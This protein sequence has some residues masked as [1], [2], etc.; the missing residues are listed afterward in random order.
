MR[1][2]IAD[3]VGPGALIGA[4]LI[5]AG[6]DVTFLD[7]ARRVTARMFSPL[8]LRSD[9]GNFRQ[10]AHHIE[11]AEIFSA[12]DVI[13][14]AVRANEISALAEVLPRAVGPGTVILSLTRG[15]DHVA[16]LEAAC[17]CAGILDGLHDIVVVAGG[18][19]D[20]ARHV[21]GTNQI[22]IGA[23]TSSEKEVAQKVAGLFGATDLDVR[24]VTDLGHQRWEQ[25][26][27]TVAVVGLGALMQ[28]DLER[29][30]SFESDATHL[31]ALV[32]ECAAV[33]DAAGYRIDIPELSQFME[34][35]PNSVP[36][37][38]KSMLGGVAKG[39][40]AEIKEMIEQMFRA[41]RFANVATPILDI[42]HTA[43][44]ARVAQAKF[45]ANIEK[46]ALRSP[47]PLAPPPQR[48]G[49]FS[50]R[51]SFRSTGGR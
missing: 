14:L 44:A 25:M 22:L 33:A 29:I 17:H 32:Q 13:I 20:P 24:I 36:A 5:D 23:R 9:L 1:I 45:N 7:S 2:L 4:Q 42:I 18:A 41:A 38:I 34:R 46:A 43:L 10:H 26:V 40:L 35:L 51:W 21:G 50:R 47:V 8:E 11:D 3:S 31:W 27:R 15:I 16:L 30:G 19:S 6:K 48:A 12:Y 37:V 28:V 49:W 39:D